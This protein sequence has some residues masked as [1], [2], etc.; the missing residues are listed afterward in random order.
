MRDV[1][2]A[3]KG[4]PNPL[5][6]YTVVELT[7]ATVFLKEGVEGGKQVEGRSFGFHSG[8]NAGR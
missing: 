5:T 1:G 6:I 2:P 4:Q 7:A 8:S 3:V